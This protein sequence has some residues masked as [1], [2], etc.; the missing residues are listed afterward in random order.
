MLPRRITSTEEAR[1]HY[2]TV[3]SRARELDLMEFETGWI[4]YSRL[5]PEEIAKGQ[6]LGLAAQIIDRET[7]TITGHAS[8]PWATYAREHSAAKKSGRTVGRQIWPWTEQ[9]AKL[10]VRAS[11]QELGR[12]E[13]L[14]TPAAEDHWTVTPQPRAEDP[15]PPD[16]SYA[17]D[18]QSLTAWEY[19]GSDAMHYLREKA[20]GQV[21]GRRVYPR[22]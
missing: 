21:T 22:I 7:G 5:T 13:Y 3:I 17:V 2:R 6:Q 14:V 10:V 16:V 18:G 20:A 12:R 1:Q 19:P 15:Q 9:Q 11:R 4:V 8:G